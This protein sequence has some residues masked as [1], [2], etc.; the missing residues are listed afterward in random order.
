M[1]FLSEFNKTLFREV[2]NSINVHSY[3]WEREVTSGYECYEVDYYSPEMGFGDNK[4]KFKINGIYPTCYFLDTNR[5]TRW[6]PGFLTCM[7]FFSRT[8]RRYHKARKGV[9]KYLRDQEKIER[10]REIRDALVGIEAPKKEKRIKGM[11]A[12]PLVISCQTESSDQECRR[13]QKK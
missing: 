3:L 11:I 7:N 4:Y 10:L 12:K 2:T 5:Q 1:I 13:D 8:V 9:K 6:S